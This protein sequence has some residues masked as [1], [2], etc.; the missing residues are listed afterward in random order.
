[1]LTG[2]RRTVAENIAA[3]LGISEVHAELLPQQKADFVAAWQPRHKVAMIGDGINDAPALARADVGLAI[4]GTGAD[5]AAEAGDVVFMGDPLRPLPLLVRLSRETVRIIR[6]NILIFAFGV[7]AVGIVTT[8]WL[9]PLLAPPQWYEQSPVAAVVYHQLG[10]LAVLLNAMRL[11]WFERGTTSP[12]FQ[13]LNGGLLRVNDWLEH[14]FDIDEAFHWLSHQWKPVLAGLL[15]LIL[16]GW[17][18]SGLNAIGSG[19]GRRGAPVRPAA[20]RRT[21]TPACTGAGRGRSRR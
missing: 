4:G 18:L 16:C 5:I 7:N 21:W 13:R 15:L 17:G 11:L 12:L 3:T 1:M 14:R 20:R 19:R 6:Q 10:S 9:W 2:D 8:A